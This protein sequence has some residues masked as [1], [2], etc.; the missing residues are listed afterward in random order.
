MHAN[1]NYVM[2]A[3]RELYHYGVKG[4][5]WGVRQAQEAGREL[6][7]KK[8]AYKRA[9][10]ARNVSM[11]RGEG[12]ESIGYKTDKYNI[13]KYEYKQAKK[14]FNDYAPS[15]V[16]AQRGARNAT[17]ALA[18]IGALHVVDKK[19]LGGV[20]TAAT[21]VAAEA[22]VK[23]IGMTAITAYTMARGGSNIKW[24]V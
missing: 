5:K 19:Y 7:K 18:K 11:L 13:A 15:R 6:D 20:G 14:E 24:K 10:L 22:A 21:K 2:L 3:N 17:V 4:M 16:K 12:G 1:S 8:R 9:K 23:V